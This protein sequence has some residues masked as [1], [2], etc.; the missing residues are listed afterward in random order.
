V[1]NVEKMGQIVKVFLTRRKIARVL[2]GLVVFFITTVILSC[3]LGQ[4]ITRP[5]EPIVP[6]QNVENP[7]ALART[8]VQS[9]TVSDNDLPGIP[10]SGPLIQAA[11]LVYLGAFRLPDASIRP[12]TF[13]YGGNAMTFYPG[14]D[15]S[16]ASDGFPGSLYITGHDRLPYGELPDGDQVAELSIPVPKIT[17]NLDELNLA[18]FIQDFQDIAKGFFTG[19]DEIPRIGMAYL[20]TPA[21]GPKIH[22]AWG[23]HLQP[24]P[25]AASHAWF[26]LDLKAPDLQGVWFIGNQSLYSVNGYM[27]EIPAQW[28]EQY[29]SGRVLATGRFRDGGWSGMGPALFAFTPWTDDQ[30]TPAETGSHLKETVLLLYE[31][32]TNTENIERSMLDYQHPDEW[33]GGAWLSTR[34]GKSGVL[35][36]GTKS[37][38]EKYWYGYVNPSGAQLPCVEGE[39]VGQFPLCRQSDGSVCP[40]QDLVECTGHSDYRG[41][42]STHFDAEFILYNPD[43][44]ARVARGEIDPWIPQPYA[45]VDI[46]EYLLQNPGGVEPDMIGTGDQRRFRIGDVAFDRQNGLL[47]LLELFADRAKPVVHVWQIQ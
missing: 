11:D 36:A 16:G 2:Q 38:G 44:L 10:T 37:N 6:T 27:F 9:P 43:D 3:G 18:E 40:E 33:E 42:W 20:D 14:G 32:S 5:A 12:K 23:Q 46:D 39:M 21:T 24:D 47:Y 1:S 17:K 31:N 41:W 13:E 34:S 8:E 22:L 26:G 15:L 28:A 29:T 35:F 45:T 30:G 19:L 25:P 7:T 4:V